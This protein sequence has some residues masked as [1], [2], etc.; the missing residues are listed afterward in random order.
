VKILFVSPFL[1]YPPVA[2]GHRQIW[3]WLTRLARDHEVAF[4]GFLERETEAGAAAEVGR[5]CA[6]TR[7]RLRCP[8]AHGYRAFAQ[9]PRSVTEFFSEELAEEV[10]SAARGFRPDVVQ[11]LATPWRSITGAGERRPRW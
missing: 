5:L 3:S 11:F 6:E 7:V 8:T 9:R 4:V 10:R 1:P 2:G